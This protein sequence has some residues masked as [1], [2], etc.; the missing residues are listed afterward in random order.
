MGMH[1]L[2]AWVSIIKF[3]ERAGSVRGDRERRV[4]RRCRNRA[5]W[6]KTVKDEFVEKIEESQLYAESSSF[7]AD[8]DNLLAGPEMSTARPAALDQRAGHQGHHPGVRHRRVAGGGGVL[9]GSAGWSV[10]QAAT[11]A[12]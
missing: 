12:V 3:A 6:G 8:M 11:E 10:C 7:R 5:E 2:D 1:D 9:R 4:D